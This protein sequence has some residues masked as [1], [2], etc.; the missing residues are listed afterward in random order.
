MVSKHIVCSYLL[1]IT[2][3]GYPPP[4]DGMLAHLREMQQLG[5]QSIEL[6]G[7]RREHLLAVCSQ[8]QEIKQELLRLGLRVPVFCTVLPGLASGRNT[9]RRENLRLF[10]KGCELAAWIG[11]RWVLDNG[12]LPP[13]QFESNIPIVRHYDEEILLKATLPADLEWGSHW[14]TLVSQYREICDIASSHGLSY[15]IHPSLGTLASGADGFLRLY[16]AVGRDNLRFVIDTS[17]QF[18]MKENLVVAI[19]RLKGMVEYIHLS[20]NNGVRMEHLVP[21][22][23]KI[24]WDAVCAEIQRGFEGLIGIDVGGAESGILDIDDAY[25]K[26][27]RWVEQRFP[28]H[29]DNNEG[30]Q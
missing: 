11:A 24:P 23:G 10:E 15:H 7:I 25:L 20:D 21:G 12:P 14:S 9:E 16:D 18:L 30:V 22:K 4:A 5:F 3:H 2:K 13:Y 29:R 26:T 6:E 8:R 1:I 27:V 17:N 19:R 28:G